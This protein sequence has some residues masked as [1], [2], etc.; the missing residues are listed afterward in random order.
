MPNA[1]TIA[2]TCL[3]LFSLNA[4]AAQEPLWELGVGLSAL[5]LPDYRGSSTTQ[6][7]LLPYP[8]II[9]RG[10]FLE[11]DRDN[12]KGRLF[13]SDRIDLDISVAAAPPVNSD[14]N[15]ARDGMDD[16]N[17]AA[18]IGPSLE[19]L[20]FGSKED[21]G[22]FLKL[23]VR[24][25]IATD[26]SDFTDAGWTFSPYL[27]YKDK[28]FF[29]DWTFSASLGPMYATARYHDY[30]YG[31]DPVDAAAGR[32]AYSATDG[33]SGSRV[34]LTLDK[35][36]G[37]DYWVGA[38]MRYDDLSGASFEDSPLV[39]QDHSLMAGIAFTWFFAH[40]STMVERN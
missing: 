11:I 25:V 18:E 26:L 37:R 17:P 14:N 40:S 13:T 27:Q 23:P 7:Y 38:F 5:S 34:T 28:H 15:D 21:S 31:V 2:A 9:Y 12:I 19:I 8:H 16:L 39:E 1:K 10:D 32:P 6:D 36:I 4:A 35:R 3:T 30:Y 20:L 24:K 33:Y 29:G 22:F